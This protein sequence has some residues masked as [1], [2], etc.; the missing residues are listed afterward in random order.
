MPPLDSEEKAI[1]VSVELGEW[2]SV[3]N[4][5][6]EMERYQRDAQWQMSLLE[7]VS[8][9]LPGRDW[10][11]LQDLAQQAG[12]SVSLL[13]ASVLHQYIVHQSGDSANL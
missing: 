5:N 11:T 12:V 1:L 3:S 4:L 9:Q 8:I 10:Q 7:T 13:I 6:Q 2:Q